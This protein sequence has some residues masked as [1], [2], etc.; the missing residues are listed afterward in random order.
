[1]LT[2]KPIL[3]YMKNLFLALIAVLGICMGSTQKLCAQ[4][5]RVFLDLRGSVAMPVGGAATEISFGY[6]QTENLSL[7]L[8][9]GYYDSFSTVEEQ[10]RPEGEGQN[11]VPLTTFGGELKFNSSPEEFFNAYIGAGIYWGWIGH[12]DYYYGGY[13]NN[14]PPRESMPLFVGSA[15]IELALSYSIK[16]Y[17][18]GGLQYTTGKAEYIDAGVSSSI[19]IGLKIIL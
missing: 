15:G 16:L 12:K 8:G 11:H 14:S 9:L 10:S 7:E 6:F 2:H 18:E 4:E 13:Y 19:G 5:G 17:F 1:M 3:L